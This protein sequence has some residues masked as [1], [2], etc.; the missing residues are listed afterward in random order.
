MRHLRANG[1]IDYPEG[2]GQRGNYPIFIDKAEPT[3]GPLRGWRLRLAAGE[4]GSSDFSNPWYQYF[5][6]TPFEEAYPDVQ[7]VVQAV[8][9]RVVQAVD[10]AVVQV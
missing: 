7:V 5:S 3:L 4:P 6:P 2:S 10:T 1:Y 8:D 9:W